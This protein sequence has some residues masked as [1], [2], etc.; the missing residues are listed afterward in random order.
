MPELLFAIFL[1][2]D[3]V[4]KIGGHNYRDIFPEIVQAILLCPVKTGVYWTLYLELIVYNKLITL[5]Q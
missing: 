3:T 2:K 1:Y 5:S 4:F